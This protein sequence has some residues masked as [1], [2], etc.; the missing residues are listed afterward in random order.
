MGGGNKNNRALSTPDR[1]GVGG[2]NEKRKSPKPPPRR[3]TVAASAVWRR[4]LTSGF[5][6]TAAE[7]T[8][9]EMHSMYVLVATRDAG[10]PRTIRAVRFHPERTTRAVPRGNTELRPPSVGNIKTAIPQNGKTMYTYTLSLNRY[11]VYRI[12]NPN[13]I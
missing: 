6:T 2:N 11:C 5:L 13:E 12:K 8:A 1:Y 4:R 9:R 10:F 7:R 3:S